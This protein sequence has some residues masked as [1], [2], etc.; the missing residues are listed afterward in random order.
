[1]ESYFRGGGGH[2]KDFNER[3]SCDKELQFFVMSE[4]TEKHKSVIK[5]FQ[6]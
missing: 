1:M 3:G 4:I 5:G 6:S 2:N